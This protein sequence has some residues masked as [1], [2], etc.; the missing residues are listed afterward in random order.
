MQFNVY[1]GREEVDLRTLA[2]RECA[3]YPPM[4]C[5]RGRGG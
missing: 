4:W 1:Q 5:H 3:L 2:G